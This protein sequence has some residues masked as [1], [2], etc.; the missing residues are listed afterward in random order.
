MNKLIS[1]MKLKFHNFCFAS[2][3]RYADDLEGHYSTLLT[4][5]QLFSDHFTPKA[6]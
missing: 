2:Y 6:V 5:E 1:D 3:F 4:S